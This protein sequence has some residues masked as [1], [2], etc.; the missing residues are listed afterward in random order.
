MKQDISELLWGDVV[1]PDLIHVVQHPLT[2]DVAIPG[3]M[4]IISL[5]NIPVIRC[6]ILDVSGTSPVL[7]NN[8]TLFIIRASNGKI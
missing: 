2:S 5:R 1:S 7:G 8:R 6:E 4:I 3:P